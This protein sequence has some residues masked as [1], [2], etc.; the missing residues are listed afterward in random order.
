MSLILFALALLGSPESGR[1]GRL[2]DIGPAPI[3]SLTDQHGRPF[4]LADLR[5]KAVLVSFIFTTCNGTCPATTRQLFR[6]Q[7]ELKRSRLFGD[8]VAFVSI[9]LDPERDS[10]EV[11]LRYARTFGCDPDHWYF[12]TGTADR[13]DAVLRAWDMWAKRDAQGVLDHPSRTFLLDTRGHVR[14][15]YN[16]DLLAPRTVL[17]D[18]RS[19]LDEPQPNAKPDPEAAY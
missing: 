5:N 15:I 8:R 18:V 9:T 19:L 14:E 7:E 2:A 10:P 16:L 13:I 3:V 17:E 4:A 6:I 12:L 11:L 1:P